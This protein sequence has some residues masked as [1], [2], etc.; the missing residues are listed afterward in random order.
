METHNPS[1]AER[2]QSERDRQ[3]TLLLFC[4]C[5]GLLQQ[6]WYFS[7]EKLERLV[8]LLPVQQIFL[9]RMEILS[10]KLLGCMSRPKIYRLHDTISFKLSIS[11][12]RQENLTGNIKDQKGIDV[13]VPLCYGDDDL[14]SDLQVSDDIEENVILQ[15]NRHH[16]S[17][18]NTKWSAEKLDYLYEVAARHK[19][20]NAREKYA[21][22]VDI[23]L[24][25]GVPD[26]TFKAFERKLSRLQI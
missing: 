10:T 18:M 25:S 7:Y 5:V 8:Q 16:S 6:G 15:P 9:R 20:L 4:S 26:K 22:Y 24:K 11:E 19:N 21:K 17:S 3:T 12:P 14:R 23:C 1:E 13:D 2:F